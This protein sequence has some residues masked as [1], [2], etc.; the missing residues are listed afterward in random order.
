MKM[1]NQ[2]VNPQT[3][4]SQAFDLAGSRLPPDTIVERYRQNYGLG[5]EIGLA[6]VR[7]HI[8]LEAALTKEL[9]ESVPESR[10]ETFA[11][12]YSRLYLE[13]PW[14]ASTGGGG[15]GAD[16]WK[17]LLRPGSRILEIGSGAGGL[18]Q[19]LA[20]DG[21]DCVA[22]E[23]SKGRG[24]IMSR[25]PLVKWSVS[26]GVNLQ[27]FHAPSSFD[28]VISDQ[29]VEHLHPDDIITHCRAA[30]EV[31]KPGGSYFIRTPH[32]SVG[33]SDLSRVLG[34]DEAVFMHLH[35]FTYA[36]F[37]EISRK[38][39]FGALRAVLYVPVLRHVRPSRVFY[40]YMRAL[41]RL[42]NSLLRLKGRH[43]RKFRSLARLGLATSN[44][45][46]QLVK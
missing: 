4:P 13:L 14:L 33:P 7:E 29:V 10:W 2:F 6:H 12:A 45:W 32:R 31:L 11:S 37:A 18:I 42:E 9:L 24:E 27:K 40:A 35:E 46:V 41:D 26:D 25:E 19:E 38:S 15:S 16:L 39:G 22:T 5:K 36:E 3:N 20:R 43:R 44:V 21:F 17:R 23:I 34:L 1:D 8:K 30:F 28:Y